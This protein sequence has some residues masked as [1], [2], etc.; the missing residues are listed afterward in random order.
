MSI[1]PAEAFEGGIGDNNTVDF[2]VSVIP[3]QT[4]PIMYT[5]TAAKGANDNAIAN[6]DFTASADN[7]ETIGTNES[8]DTI[9]VPIIGD[10]M[11]EVNEN[12]YY[13]FGTSTRRIRKVN[14]NSIICTGYD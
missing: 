8:E 3:P 5:W 4:D 14:S 13:H 10:D 2:T 6:T 9:S 7:P 12:F 11:N 1:A